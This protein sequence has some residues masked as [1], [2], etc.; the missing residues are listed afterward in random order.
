MEIGSETLTPIERKEGIEADN[1]YINPLGELEGTSTET[2]NKNHEINGTICEDSSPAA[3]WLMP[4]FSN[5]EKDRIEEA[6]K[7]SVYY[8]AISKYNSTDLR[9]LEY[10]LH[11]LESIANWRDVSAKILAFRSKIGIITLEIEKSQQKMA[12]Y[13]SRN[14]CQYCGGS[15]RGLLAKTCSKCGRKKDY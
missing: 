15:F 10:A 13:R 7:D 3:P 9:E 11:L 14:V 4:P 8:D 2:H 12:E 6:F 1:A 5:A